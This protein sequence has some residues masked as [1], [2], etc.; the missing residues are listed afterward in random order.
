MRRF[1]RFYKDEQTASENFPFKRSDVLEWTDYQLQTRN[2]YVKWLFPLPSDEPP[3]KMTSRIQY[4][5]R[6]NPEMR[7]RAVKSTRRMLN[8]FGYEINDSLEVVEN[9]PL[10]RKVGPITI[11]LYNTQNFEKITRI[12]NFLKIV[13]LDKLRSLVFLS[14]CKAMKQY[15]DFRQLVYD[16][17]VIDDWLKTQSDYVTDLTTAKEGLF[18]GMELDDWEL[19]DFDGE[20]EDGGD[21]WDL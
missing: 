10:N 5:F 6:T 14:I 11:G 18:S 3:T 2:E 15:P 20:L 16:N 4:V 13:H 12:L 7:E 9:K 17:D 8:F 19:Q 21:A 1:V